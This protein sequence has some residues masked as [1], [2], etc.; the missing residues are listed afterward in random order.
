MFERF[1]QHCHLHFGGNIFTNS[2]GST[3]TANTGELI[4]KQWKYLGKKQHWH[5]SAL[6]PPT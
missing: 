1:R 3:L 5:A 6:W 2:N 4:D